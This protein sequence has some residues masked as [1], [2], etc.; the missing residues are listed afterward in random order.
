MNESLPLAGIRVLD[1][2]RLLPGPLA[3][4]HLFDQGAEVIK[5]EDTGQGDYARTMGAMAGDSSYFYQ[6]VNRGKQSIRLNLKHAQGRDLFL[7]LVE[8][9]DVV[10]EGF[11]PGVMSRLGLGFEALHAR[12][13]KL[14]MCSIT[15]YGQ[16]GP[17]AHRAGHD[18]NYLAAAGVLDQT[19]AVAGPPALSNLQ[20]GDLLGG[21]MGAFAGIM[22]ALFAA[23][24][25]GK[26]RHLDIAMTDV[27]LAHTVF[28]M[29][30]A[31]AHGQVKPR[32]DD[33]LTGAVPCYGVY[34][35][36]DG[37]YMAVGALEEK[38][39]KLL[40]D[41]LQRPDLEP[42]HLATGEA[43]ARA[44][45]AL[46]GC[47]RSR[48]LASWRA[49]FDTVDCCV[50]PV[51]RLDEVL[52]CD[53][54]LARQR[55]IDVGGVLQ[56]APLFRPGDRSHHIKAAPE[57]GADTAA[58]LKRMLGLSETDLVQLSAQAVI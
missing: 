40:C 28:P 5:V 51:L 37:R 36:A 54:V 19:G 41:T 39:W 46:A 1:L 23:Q 43:G 33:L 8:C 58:V 14:V 21:S 53:Y 49:V 45:A 18:I 56:H 55:M 16:T 44:R 31:L 22:V 52:Q 4:Q 24:R 12:N 38:F 20:V 11:R 10:V 13:S 34:E 15:G 6:L 17:H 29:V 42:L 3:T 35:T 26:G 47:F 57:Q 25:T 30:E 48:T 7:R 9:A 27:V 50:T 2:T 32:G